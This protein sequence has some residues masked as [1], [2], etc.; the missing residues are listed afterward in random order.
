MTGLQVR[1][2]NQ[3]GMPFSL[4]VRDAPPEVVDRAAGRIHRVLDQADRVFS[5]YRP[6]SDIARL[7]KGVPATALDPDVATVMKLAAQARRITG[8]VFDI[9]AG[10]ELDPSGVVK[11]WTASRAFGVAGLARYDA[12]LGAGGDIALRTTGTGEGWRIGI[13]HPADPSGLLTV[14]TLT[15]GAIATSGTVH[16]G[17][18][19]WDPRTGGTAVSPWQATVVGPSLVWADIL[20]TAAAVTGPDLDRRRWPPGY[21]VLLVAPDGSVRMSAGIRSLLAEGTPPLVARPLDTALLDNALPL[22][23]CTLSKETR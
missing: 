10:R 21:E 3:L 22:T 15:G 8:G 13:E 20:A 4:H 6:D 12:Y 1:S 17:L 7:R 5:T 9:R 2:W 16:R 19:L 11:G 18:H 23:R 14:L